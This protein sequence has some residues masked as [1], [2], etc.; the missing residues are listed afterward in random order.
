MEQLKD[1]VVMESKDLQ[2]SFR[3]VRA[4]DG[5][6]F[7]VK[8]GQILS[9]IGPNG[10]GKTF[11]INCVTGYY[12]PQKGK[13]LFDGRNIV[14]LK[15]HLIAKLG[16]SRT[17]QN[18]TTYPHMTALEILMA[19]RHIHT[20]AS[21]METMLYFGRNRR[22]EL[23]SRR[24]AEEIIAFSHIEELRKRPLS[25]MSYGQRKQVEIARALTMQPKIIFLD[26]PMSGLDDVMKEVVSELIL[27][28]YH[29]GM[30]IVLI[31]HDMQVVMELSH[32]I[33]VLDYGRKIAEGTPA[34][35]CQDERVVAAY[36]G[37]VAS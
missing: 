4:L 8:K 35:I 13:I 32:S 1:S 15:P 19:A 24:A 25:S 36:L 27:N 12:H 7:R 10:A 6:Q 21:L 31:E 30:T 20:R 33:V 34:E 29:R 23:E 37:G 11:L 3:G 2:L 26:E 16:I 22:E 9:I 28:M 14:G 17:F 18:P 5:V